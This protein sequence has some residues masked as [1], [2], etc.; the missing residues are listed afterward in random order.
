MKISDLLRHVI[1]ATR[2]TLTRADHA[3]ALGV[4][5]NTFSQWKVGGQRP[6]LENDARIRA[7]CARIHTCY[8]CVDDPPELRAPESK[9]GAKK[10]LN[11][12]V[13]RQDSAAYARRFLQTKTLRE[14][15]FVSVMKAED[16]AALR[17]QF[18][19]VTVTEYETRSGRQAWRA[20][21]AGENNQSN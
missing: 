1:Y 9:P 7:Y 14:R 12:G 17:A 21:L 19:A 18:P 5:V 3:A 16:V 4:N 2:E 13:K 15:G 20:T 11:L 8:R 6:N 10:R